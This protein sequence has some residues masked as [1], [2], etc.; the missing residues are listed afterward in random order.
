MARVALSQP[1]EDVTVGAPNIQS[2][3]QLIGT[4]AG[5]EVTSSLVGKAQSASVSV[6]VTAP[7]LV[8]VLSIWKK[9]VVPAVAVKT[10]SASLLLAEELLLAATR[11]RPASD[12]PVYTAASVS[13]SELNADSRNRPAAGAVQRYQ[14]E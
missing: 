1:G 9:Y 7:P 10:A 4:T 3:I 6:M 2:I 5:D 13:V 14:S 12:V 8:L 11:V